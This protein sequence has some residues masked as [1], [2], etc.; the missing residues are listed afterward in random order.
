MGRN[1]L[2]SMDGLTRSASWGTMPQ[3]YLATYQAPFSLDS[4]FNGIR[5]LPLYKFFCDQGLASGP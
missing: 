5:I 1:F 4:H 3:R 2:R